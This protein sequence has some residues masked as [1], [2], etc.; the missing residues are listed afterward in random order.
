MSQLELSQFLQEHPLGRDYTQ[1]TAD[2][3]A[4]L[5]RELTN[6]HQNKNQSISWAL[7]VRRVLGKAHY[8][9]Y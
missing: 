5:A 2:Y 8:R 6:L 4:P 3:F 7:M 9:N 1:Q